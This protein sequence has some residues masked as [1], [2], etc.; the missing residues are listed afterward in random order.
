MRHREL[1]LLR[2]ARP[3]QDLLSE[4]LSLFGFPSPVVD[5][6]RDPDLQVLVDAVDLLS[7]VR[8]FCPQV[9]PVVLI[10]LVLFVRLLEHLGEVSPGKTLPPEV[11]VGRHRFFV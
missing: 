7:P 5:D 11:L 8:C 10:H 9:L 4:P 2:V 6:S 3:P 1:L